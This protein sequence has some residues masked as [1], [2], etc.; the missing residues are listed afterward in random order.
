MKDYH[1]LYLKRDDFL[2][3]DIFQK[4]RSYAWIAILVSAPP[5]RLHAM[6]NVTKVELERISDPGISLFFETGMK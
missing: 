3:A 4:I 1:E 2:L 6:L 5:L